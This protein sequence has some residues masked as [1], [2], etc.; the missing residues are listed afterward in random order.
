MAD[1][2][3]L[4]PPAENPSH[5]QLWEE[6]WKR[7]DKFLPGMFTDLFPSSKENHASVTTAQ[8]SKSDT[9]SSAKGSGEIKQ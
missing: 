8:V 2:G 1:S 5:T 3:H 4:V 6:T 7:L 9:K